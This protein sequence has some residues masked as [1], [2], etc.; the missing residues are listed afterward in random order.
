MTE[1]QKNGNKF[2]HWTK[3][4]NLDMIKSYLSAGVAEEELVKDVLDIS[5][6][7]Y[8]EWLERSPEFKKAVEE[9]LGQ[10]KKV[11][12]SLERLCHGFYVEEIK[13]D[14]VGREYKTKKYIPPQIQAIIFYLKS[15]DPENWD[16]ESTAEL[17]GNFKQ[18]VIRND[19]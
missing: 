16:K 9:G 8:N 5:E 17:K 7:T 14:S 18:L 4:E 12:K 13:T 1:R 19:L 10:V 11:V 15:R 2:K 3:E 6:K